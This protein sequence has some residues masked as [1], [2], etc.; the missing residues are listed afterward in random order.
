MSPRN[1]NEVIPSPESGPLNRLPPIP[2]RIHC[3][4]TNAAEG[5]DGELDRIALEAFLDTLA[6]VALSMAWRRKQVDE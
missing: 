3:L 4:D 2:G 1:G 5:H 6:E